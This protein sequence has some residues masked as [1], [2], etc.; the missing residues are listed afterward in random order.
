MQTSSDMQTLDAGLPL[1]DPTSRKMTVVAIKKFDLLV[2]YIDAWEDL[3]AHALEPN[4]FYEPWM[5]RPALECLGGGRDLQVVLVLAVNEGEPV[6]CGVFPI[7][8]RTQY[9]K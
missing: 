5:L 8:K 4:P 2:D 3:A 9:K 1:L 7:E 6:L